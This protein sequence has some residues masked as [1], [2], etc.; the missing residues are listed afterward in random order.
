MRQS[1]HYIQIYPCLQ[2]EGGAT[3]VSCLIVKYKTHTCIHLLAPTEHGFRLPCASMIRIIHETTTAT[4]NMQYNTKG[5]H[6]SSAQTLHLTFPTFIFLSRSQWTL[7]SAPQAREFLII[8]FICLLD[9]E[10]RTCVTKWARKSRIKL[11]F[12]L[13]WRCLCLCFSLRHIGFSRD[14][15]LL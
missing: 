11:W 7:F 14:N 5:T 3:K 15:Y 8:A 10:H 9:T 1:I 12:C 4:Q 6:H 2:N 13:F